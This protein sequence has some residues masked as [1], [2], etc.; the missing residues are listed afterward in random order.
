MYFGKP[1]L[2]LDALPIDHQRFHG[3]IDA[4]GGPLLLNV[5]AIFEAL[6]DTE[7]FGQFCF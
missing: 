3:E 4:N 6:H 2:Q 1:Y 7:E 5:R